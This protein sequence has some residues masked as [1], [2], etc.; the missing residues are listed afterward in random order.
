MIPLKGWWGFHNDPEMLAA[1]FSSRCPYPTTSIPVRKSIARSGLTKI[2]QI[3]RLIRDPRLFVCVGGLDLIVGGPSLIRRSLIRCVA[4][5]RALQ[6]RHALQ[7]WRRA[8]AGASRC[9]DAAAAA[10]A[11]EDHRG[12]QPSPRALS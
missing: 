11:A 8:A 9:A 2:A 12:A 10:T 6:P 3:S 7:N 1:P 5:A 4:G